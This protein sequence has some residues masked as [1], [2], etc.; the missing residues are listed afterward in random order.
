MA[1]TNEQQGAAYRIG[2]YPGT[3]DPITKGHIHII[4]RA[5]K[6][7]DHLIVTVADNSNKS[8]LFSVEER[9]EL[10]E[11]DIAFLKEGGFSLEVK[12][13]DD[14]LVRFAR[15]QGASVVFRGLRAVSDFEYEFQMTGMNAQLEPSIETL[16]L[17]ASDKY[18]YVS[19]AFVK[20]I[21]RLNGDIEPFVSKNV[22]D[23]LKK[24][25]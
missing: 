15:E 25:L 16:F 20:E 6:L 12:S 7:V 24:A 2:I 23:H 3:F 13:T 19:S 22:A 4:K 18:Q 10:V 11:N 21:C 5:V 1:S 14:L 8:P 9:V 17:M